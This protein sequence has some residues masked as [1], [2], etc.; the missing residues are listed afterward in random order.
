MSMRAAAPAEAPPSAPTKLDRLCGRLIATLGWK[1]LGIPNGATLVPFGTTATDLP[2]IAI[3]EL[4]PLLPHFD[5]ILVQHDRVS[6]VAICI[7]DRTRPGSTPIDIPRDRLH[8]VG[9]ALE[10]YCNTVY[11]VRMA[12]GIEVWEVGAT[13]GSVDHLAD[14]RPAGRRRG[15]IHLAAWSIGLEDEEVWTS[16]PLG[17]ALTLRDHLEQQLFALS[18]DEPVA[19]PAPTA[20]VATPGSAPLATWAVLATIGAIFAWQ[21]SRNGGF[22]FSLQSLYELGGLHIPSVRAGDWTRMLTAIFL[23]GHALHLALNAM[24]LLVTGATLESLLGRAHFLAIFLLSGLAG[25]TASFLFLDPRLISVGAS[26]AIFGLLACAL[27]VIRRLP[28]GTFG[29][30]AR[31]QLYL[32]SAPAFLSMLT[33]GGNPGIDVAAHAGGA[34]AG[35]LLGLGIVRG[36]RQTSLPP[37]F[38]R[39]ARAIAV[40]GGAA[41]AFAFAR[42]AVG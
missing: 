20:T 19:L 25:T 22:A 40:V 1:C 5:R 36:R 41:V 11:G 17:G 24:P 6:T 2:L 9:R 15:E 14:Y 31:F 42:I 32:W 12:A 39:A 7:R 37:P 28:P 35:A 23:H 21:L 4:E 38:P 3:P 27:V 26:G 13:G 30:Q 8:A 29:A 16:L 34:L 10:R 18:A 33:N